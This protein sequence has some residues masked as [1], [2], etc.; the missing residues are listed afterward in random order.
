[1]AK[2][3]MKELLSRDHLRHF[4]ARPRLLI[5]L[6]LV[7]F[8]FFAMPSDWKQPTRLLSAWNIGT[9]LYI[10][11]TIQA[12]AKATE[13]SIRRYALVGDESRFIILALCIVAAVASL[14]AIIVQ[15]GSV[16]SYEGIYKA[17]HL[18]LAIGTIVSAFVFIHLVFTQHYAHEFF[19]ERASEEGLPAEARGGLRFPYTDKPTFA[20]FAYYSFVIGCACQTADVETTSPPMRTLTLI[21]GVLAFFFNTT[22]LALTINISSGLV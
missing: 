19:I 10:T 9:W 4:T 3:T 22:V 8:S 16:K 18:A 20:D 7:V 5:C 15:L 6:A 12:M 2:S 11:L 14:V 13:A 1:M 21:H 17:G